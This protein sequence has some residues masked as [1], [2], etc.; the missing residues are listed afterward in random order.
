MG[1]DNLKKYLIVYYWSLK[2]LL[3]RRIFITFAD[4]KNTIYIVL[5][6]MLITVSCS[7]DGGVGGEL[8][9]IDS[10]ADTRADSAL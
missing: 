5:F 2:R 10:L 8:A 4:M 7:G 3:Q 9:A 6:I 1:V